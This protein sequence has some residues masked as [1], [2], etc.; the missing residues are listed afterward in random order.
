MQRWL[1]NFAYRVNQRVDVFFLSGLIAGIIA[2]ATVCYH[3]VKAGLSSP[4]DSLRYE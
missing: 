3:A 4:V 1:G 2:L